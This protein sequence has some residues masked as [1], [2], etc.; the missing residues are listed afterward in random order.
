[1]YVGL[2]ICAALGFLAAILLDYGERVLL[3]W[4]A[5]QA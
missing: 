3:P 5:R 2:L 4:K 1:M